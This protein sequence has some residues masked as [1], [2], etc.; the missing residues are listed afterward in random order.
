MNIWY[1]Q[2]PKIY[3]RYNVPLNIPLN[4]AIPYPILAKNEIFSK[5]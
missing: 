2:K 4:K 5:K 3:K 1:E